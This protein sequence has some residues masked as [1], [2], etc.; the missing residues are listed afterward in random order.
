MDT[1]IRGEAGRADKEE[2][3]R[4]LPLERAC[5]WVCVCGGRRGEDLD[6]EYYI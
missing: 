5:V 3:E 6:H 2:V 4:V 1:D